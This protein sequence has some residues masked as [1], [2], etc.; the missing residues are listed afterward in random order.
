[1][2]RTGANRGPRRAAAA[3]EAVQEAA[4]LAALEECAAALG[5]TDSRVSINAVGD[6][7]L[8]LDL[9]RGRRLRERTRQRI[10]AFLESPELEAAAATRLAEL[11]AEADRLRAFMAGRST[12]TRRAA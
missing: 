6:A 8:I 1:M 12:A 3:T 4:L 2:R 11:E 7:A 5:W 10:R 9:R